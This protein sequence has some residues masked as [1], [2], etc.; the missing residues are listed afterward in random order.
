M[1]DAKSSE[2]LQS[3]PPALGINPNDLP[4]ILTDNYA[5]LVSERIRINSTAFSQD[6]S[7]TTTRD[8]TVSFLLKIAETYETVTSLVEDPAIRKASAFVSG[9]AYQILAKSMFKFL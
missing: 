1:F 6:D 4:R 9:T 5:R 3:A 8:A 2:L 7:F